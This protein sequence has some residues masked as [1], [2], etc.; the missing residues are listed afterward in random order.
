MSKRTRVKWLEIM[1]LSC[2]RVLLRRNAS[3]RDFHGS[4]LEGKGSLISG[5]VNEAAIKRVVRYQ[6]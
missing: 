5:P 1:N 2:H 6:W 3:W 4:H